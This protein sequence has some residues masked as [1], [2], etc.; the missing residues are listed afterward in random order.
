[1]TIGTPKHWPG[2]SPARP[3]THFVPAANPFVAAVR[4]RREFPP[5][6]NS[7]GRVRGR[8]GKKV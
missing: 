1:M 5:F 7:N 3:F 6:R 2:M 8:Q 4:N